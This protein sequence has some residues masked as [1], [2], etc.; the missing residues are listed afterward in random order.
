MEMIIALNCWNNESHVWHA[1]HIFLCI[2]CE[3]WDRG[4]IFSS[5]S[6]LQTLVYLNISRVP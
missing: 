6:R 4:N 1:G 2:T 5:Q 3:N